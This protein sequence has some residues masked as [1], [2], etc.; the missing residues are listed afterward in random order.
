MTCSLSIQVDLERGLVTLGTLHVTLLRG[1]SPGTLRVESTGGPVVGLLS[2]AERSRLIADAL[3]EEDPPGALIQALTAATIMEG[4]EL[5]PVVL[6]AVVLALAGGGEE[7]VSFAETGVEAAQACGWNWH[8]LNDTPALMVDRAAV[9]TAP[10]T[11][12]GWRRIVFTAAEEPDLEALCREMVESLLNRGASQSAARTTRRSAQ[13]DVPRSTPP[14]VKVQSALETKPVGPTEPSVAAPLISET[15]RRRAFVIRRPGAKGFPAASDIPASTHTP[16]RRLR[17]IILPHE[18]PKEVEQQTARSPSTCPVPTTTTTTTAAS[19]GEGIVVLARGGTVSR[20]AVPAVPGRAALLASRTKAFPPAPDA[21]PNAP[22]PE[23]PLVPLVHA[24]DSQSPVAAAVMAS[25]PAAS[26]E[27]N[28]DDW[29]DELARSVE[30]ECDLR[31][32]EA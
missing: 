5:D 14:R 28:F 29:F 13:A 32:I 22:S 9:T 7:A 21:R 12:D 1:P 11:D 26:A 8:E 10:T 17:W 23:Q 25:P 27:A 18:M 24:V 16:S 2:F 20:K 31:G 19:T 3:A 30:A 15:G 6:R 4:G